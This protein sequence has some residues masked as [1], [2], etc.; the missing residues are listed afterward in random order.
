M[1]SVNRTFTAPCRYTT[2]HWEE[3]TQTG[4][5]RGQSHTLTIITLAFTLQQLLR[6]GRWAR[7]F[8]CGL[9]NSPGSLKNKW[10]KNDRTFSDYTSGKDFRHLIIYYNLIANS[11]ANDLSVYIA[12]K[13]IQISRAPVNQVLLLSAFL[14]EHC[15]LVDIAHITEICYSPLM[16]KRFSAFIKNY[17]TCW[18]FA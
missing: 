11:V 7:Y 12:S 13:S 18:G 8:L 4:P 16:R 6:A 1:L 9:V 2:L 3:S 17:A 14:S 5:K 10:G 15:H